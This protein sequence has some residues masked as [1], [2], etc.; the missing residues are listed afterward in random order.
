[1]AARSE[2]QRKRKALEE[3]IV[4][5]RIDLASRE[6]GLSKAVERHQH[7]VG[8]KDFREVASV[9]ADAEHERLLFR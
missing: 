9:Y 5:S 4:R 8:T 7:Q 1:M 6:Y 2:L 3:Q